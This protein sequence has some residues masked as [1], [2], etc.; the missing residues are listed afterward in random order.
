M[1]EAFPQESLENASA[2]DSPAMATKVELTEN[3]EKSQELSPEREEDEDLASMLNFEIPFGGLNGTLSDAME[4]SP[5]S[6]DEDIDFL[7]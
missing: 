1:N 7:F 6:Y 2:V 4:C 5:R 3:K